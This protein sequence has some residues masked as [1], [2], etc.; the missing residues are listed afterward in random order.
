[1]NAEKFI[2]FLCRADVAKVNTEYI[3]YSTPNKAALELMDAEW[4]EDET[5][6]PPQEVLDRCEIFHDL[7]DFIEVYNEAWLKIK[8]AN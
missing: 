7:G 5:Y 1:E 4:I 2:D 3:G 8:G 6:N